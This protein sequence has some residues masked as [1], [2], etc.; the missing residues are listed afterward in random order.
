MPKKRETDGSR[1]RKIEK[2]INKEKERVRRLKESKKELVF[3]PTLLH[4]IRQ[5]NIHGTRRNYTKKNK[6]AGQSYTFSGT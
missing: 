4:A 6:L 2:R 3:D 1:E 5:S